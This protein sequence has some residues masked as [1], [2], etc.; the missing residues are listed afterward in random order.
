MPRRE[1]RSNE[2]IP[3]TLPVRLAWTDED[4]RDFYARGNCRDISP[5]GLRVET[6]ETIPAHSYV[7]LRVADGDVTGSAR[8]R[9]LRRGPARNIV[10]LELGE[11]VREQL[12]EVLRE[13]T[14]QSSATASGLLVQ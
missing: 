14:Q 8:V 1:R 11:K 10:G 7:M 12:L 13:R 3:Y 5:E 9:Y 2:R 4:G 6:N